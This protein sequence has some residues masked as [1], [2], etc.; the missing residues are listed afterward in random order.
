MDRNASQ[1]VS[2]FRKKSKIHILAGLLNCYYC[3]EIFFSYSDSPRKDGYKPSLYR[4][5]SKERG[6]SCTS[7]MAS[8]VKIGPILIN[9]IAN[10]LKLTKIIAKKHK[11]IP[12]KLFE[13]ALLS[14]DTLNGIECI[15][16]DGLYYLYNNMIHKPKS[17]FFNSNEKE[18]HKNSSSINEFELL[19][20]KKE[21]YS[22]ALIKLSDLYLID[23]AITKNDY[24]LKKRELEK[25]IHEIDIKIEKVKFDNSDEKSFIAKTNK[26]T[27]YNELLKDG[28]VDFRK[29]VL[30]NE[31]GFIKDFINMIID[32]IVVKDSRILSINFKNGLCNKF[33]YKDEKT[34]I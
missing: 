2:H 34:L 32:N 14:G 11:P 24:L 15:D 18:K 10:I 20:K 27:F 7:T 31:T 3:G 19:T 22:K 26:F 25:S 21:S 8:E 5:K 12:I 16:P 28:E 13:K 17:A 6:L 9:Y 29:L 4:C 33:I 30:T 1:N 23:E